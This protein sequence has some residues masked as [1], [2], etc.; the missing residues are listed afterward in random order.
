MGNCFD[1][2][3]GTTLIKD[4]QHHPCNEAHT[5]EVIFVG[6]LTGS[7]DAY[8][9]NSVIDAFAETNCI[10]AYNAYTG[11]DFQN[12]AEINIAWFYPTTEGWKDGDRGVTCYAIRLDGTAMTTSVKKAP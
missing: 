3:V 4:V 7:N 5:S 6:S 10:P 1:E 2:P 11:R 8:P 9:A 12:D